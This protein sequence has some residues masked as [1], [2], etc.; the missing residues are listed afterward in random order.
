MFNIRESSQ[1]GERS[2]LKLDLDEDTDVRTQLRAALCNNA[3]RIIDLF[4]DWDDDESGTINKNEWRKAMGQ[5]QYDVPIEEID[6]LFDSFDPDGSG[7]IDY[8]ELHKMLRG[9]TDL[10]VKAAVAHVTSARTP[11]EVKHAQELRRA[12]DSFEGRRVCE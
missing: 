8:K 5:F 11:R 10:S 4:R 6:A 9:T 12:L 1:L 7:V 3:V 2:H